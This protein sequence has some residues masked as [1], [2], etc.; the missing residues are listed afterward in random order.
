M[1]LF[2]GQYFGAALH[3]F[4]KGLSQSEA[5]TEQILR[6]HGIDHVDPALWYDLNTARSIYYTVGKQIGERSLQAVGLQMIDSAPFPPGI[7][8]I[9]SVLQSLDHAYHMNVRGPEIGYISCDFEGEGNALVTFAT[10]FPCALS[11]GILRGCARKFAPE[12]LVEHGPDGCIDGGAASCT[13][14]VTW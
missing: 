9:K 4:V 2:E 12:A 14:H 13:F 8:D 3:S 7:N 1:K 10:P 11:R 5:L 6:S